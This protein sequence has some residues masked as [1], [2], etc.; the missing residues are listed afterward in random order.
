M[1]M[2]TTSVSGKRL[3]AAGALLCIAGV[4][5]AQPEGSTPWMVVPSPNGGPQPLGN[6]LNAVEALSPTDA[7]A[8]GFHYNPAHCEYC[9]TPLSMHWNG[10][11]WSLVSTPAIPEAQKAQLDDIDAVSST[12]IWAVG[13]G[14]NNNCG[15]CGW[16]VIQHWD[17]S[18]WTR[19]QSP[20][21]GLANALY[22]VAAVSATDV[23]AVGDQWLSFSAKVPLIVHYDGAAWTPVAYPPIEYG[24]LDSVFALGANDVWAVGVAGVISTGIRGLAFHWDGASWTEVP[25]PHEPGGYIWLR[26]ISGVA[27]NDV[28]AVGVYKYVNHNGHA[29]ASARTWHWDGTSWSRVPQSGVGGHDSR[30]YGVHAISSDDVWAVGGGDP[31]LGSNLAFEYQTVHWDGVRWSR[32]ENPNQAVL[33]AVGG[34]SR[35]DVWAVGWGMDSLGYSTGTHT[36]HHNGSPPLC[37]ANCDRSATPPA[38]NVQDFSCFLARFAAWDPYANCD[39]STEWPEFN[40]QDFSCFLTR[41]AAGCP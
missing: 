6:T 32:V 17:G 14:I 16:T 9:P 25:L 33:L 26:S 15:L 21:P 8:V 4:A 27:S 37:Y 29:I 35:S 30:M 20:N 23:W 10:A 3:A 5:H 11:A 41:Y 36:L 28:W 12:D 13:W 7:W 38:L 40:V 24:Q 2:R 39:G 34:S 22:G 31:P 1:T 19:A 18:S